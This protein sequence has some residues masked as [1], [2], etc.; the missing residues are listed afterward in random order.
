V[1][2]RGYIRES[3]HSFSIGRKGYLA[4]V[5]LSYLA[6]NRFYPMLYC[7]DPGTPWDIS[8]AVLIVN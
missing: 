5:G 6:V 7:V 2:L 8:C 1:T 3:E 4:I